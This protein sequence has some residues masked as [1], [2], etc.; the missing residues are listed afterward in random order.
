[1]RGEDEITRTA[2]YLIIKL[3]EHLLG[4]GRSLMKAHPTSEI[5]C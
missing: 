5:I 2:P 3:Q 4:E 1:M